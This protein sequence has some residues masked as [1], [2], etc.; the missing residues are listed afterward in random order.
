M[1]DAELEGTA[2]LETLAGAGKLDDFMAAV[3]ADD[4]AAAAELMR[5]VDIDAATIALVLDKMSDA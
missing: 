1:D 4:F 3:D 5:S 2:V